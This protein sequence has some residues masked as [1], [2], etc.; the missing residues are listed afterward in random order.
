[1]R[2]RDFDWGQSI[3]NIIDGFLRVFDAFHNLDFA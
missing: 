2:S 1:M 3:E